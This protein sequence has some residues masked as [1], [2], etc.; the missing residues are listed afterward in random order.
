[1]TEGFG[2]SKWKRGVALLGRLGEQQFWWGKGVYQELCFGHVRCG[3]PIKNPNLL[4]EPGVWGKVKDRY[5]Y[6]FRH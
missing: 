5:I 6:F 1:M 4:C 2:L 3:M